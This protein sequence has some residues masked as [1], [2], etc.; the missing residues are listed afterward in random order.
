M[1]TVYRRLEPAVVTPQPSPIFT[2][3]NDEHVDNRTAHL[4][5][6]TGD[7]RIGG[8]PETV[9][10]WLFHDHEADIH[11]VTRRTSHKAQFTGHT[12]HLSQVATT[13]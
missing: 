9:V 12:V 7:W 13:T 6:V 2:T 5:V 3:L 8:H 11:R 1:V 10:E 4:T